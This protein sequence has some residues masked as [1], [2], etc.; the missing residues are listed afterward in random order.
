MLPATGLLLGELA[1]RSTHAHATPP[2]VAIVAALAVLGVFDALAGVCAAFVFVMGIALTGHLDTAVAGRTMLGLGVVWFAAPLIA[3]AARPL[4]RQLKNS[5]QVYRQRIADLAIASLIGAWAVQK[6]ITALPGLAQQHLPIAK[7]AAV[8]AWLVLAA[9]ALRI[10]LETVAAHWYPQRLG[11]VQPI[12]VPKSG[13]A[14]RIAAAFLRT[15]VFLFV[16]IAFIG[17]HW[18]LWVGGVIFLVPQVVSVY[19]DRLYN[20]ERLYAWLPRG[21]LKLVVMLFVGAAFG[22]Y[23]L[24]ALRHSRHVALDA[25]VL[26]TVPGLM[27]GAIELFGRDGRD[28]DEGWIRWSAGV[29]VLAVGI[30]FV[31]G[32]LN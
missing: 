5:A 10:I 18:Q 26:L 15:S 7:D 4:R 27:L 16:V 17:N 22:T 25:F 14:Q 8:I 11:D 6:M 3:G 24:H 32:Y 2:S 1:L 21:L 12:A 19:E 30:L 31:F 28:P 23:A 9:A 29:V 20:S 13:R